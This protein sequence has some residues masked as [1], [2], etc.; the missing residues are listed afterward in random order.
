MNASVFLVQKAWL[1][2]KYQNK[3]ELTWIAETLESLCVFHGLQEL[4]QLHYCAASV[5]QQLQEAPAWASFWLQNFEG[6]LL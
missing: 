3:P 6:T 4:H 5:T 2:W 1:Q